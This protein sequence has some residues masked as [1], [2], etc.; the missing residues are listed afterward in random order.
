VRA[1]D[2]AGFD[3]D[4]AKNTSLY[5]VAG[6]VLIALAAVWLV[7][8]VVTK[9]LTVAILLAIAGLVWSQRAELT[10][11]ADQ[12]RN[13]ISAGGFN[14]TECTFFG[15]GVTIPGR[16]TLLGPNNAATTTTTTP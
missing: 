1:F 6:A 7:K 11:C 9:V 12:V 2:L 8:Q 10:D 15:Q 4:T 14:D 16:D 3:L 13:T 5:T